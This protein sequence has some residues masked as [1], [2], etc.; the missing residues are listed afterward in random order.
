MILLVSVIATVG[1]VLTFRAV[2]ALVYAKPKYLPWPRPHANVAAAGPLALERAIEDQRILPDVDVVVVGASLSSLVVAAVLARTMGKRVYVFEKSADVLAARYTASTRRW[3]LCFD[4]QLMPML[5]AAAPNVRIGVCGDGCVCQ[6]AGETIGAG[7]I[8]SMRVFRGREW[9]RSLFRSFPSHRGELRTLLHEVRRGARYYAWHM[10]L[11]LFWPILRHWGILADAALHWVS[12][13]V[14]PYESNVRWSF[15]D[16]ASR[17][18]ADLV[19]DACPSLSASAGGEVLFETLYGQ[20]G[21]G[22]SGPAVVQCAYIENLRKGNWCLNGTSVATLA[23]DL[24]RSIQSAGGAVFLGA[25]VTDVHRGR[26]AGLGV[27]ITCSGR[28]GSS[29]ALGAAQVVDTVGV[30]HGLSLSSRLLDC[31]APGPVPYLLPE[32][33]SPRQRYRLAVTVSKSHQAPLPCHVIHHVGPSFPQIEATHQK[34]LDSPAQTA[35]A[36]AVLGFLARGNE[37]EEAVV[38]VTLRKPDAACDEDVVIQK[39][40]NVLATYAP[41]VLAHIARAELTECGTPGGRVS[42]CEP[43]RWSASG[44]AWFRPRHAAM[45]SGIFVTGNDLTG[46]PALCL[47]AAYVTLCYLT[48]YTNEALVCGPSFL[49]ALDS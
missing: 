15:D 7:G 8:Q 22:D 29:F 19:H 34:W 43:A 46:H 42:F 47:D 12:T 41:R 20:L 4:K 23:T 11:K 39:A 38:H 28:P 31:F 37:R 6:R 16:F 18:F 13:I 30:R 21:V 9:L 45:A 27:S 25:E 49:E 40:I 26:Y 17:P 32:W 2:T 36:P 1:F 24:I 44:E 5:A 3:P 14:W 10:K 48:G 33:A 35:C